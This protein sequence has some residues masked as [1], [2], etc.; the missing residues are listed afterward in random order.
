MKTQF[1]K[2]PL[3]VGQKLWRGEYKEDGYTIGY[4][5]HG[6]P[7]RGV[8]HGRLPAKRE[9]TPAHIKDIPE[10]ETP[11]EAAINA[12]LTQGVFNF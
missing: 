10:T 9:K 5:M 3:K 2:S 8:V 6:L 1:E 7:M 4:F 12:P 11:V